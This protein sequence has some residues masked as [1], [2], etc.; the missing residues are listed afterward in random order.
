[1]ERKQIQV[2]RIRNPQTSQTIKQ[3]NIFYYILGTSGKFAAN[4]GAN[5]GNKKKKPKVPIMMGNAM[6][7]PTSN[8]VLPSAE[9]TP[10]P[11]DGFD[12]E[13]LALFW[14]NKLDCDCFSAARFM[15]VELPHSI[16]AVS[17]ATVYV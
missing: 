8:P 6:S 16:S 14:E 15:S 11:P 13:L 17:S 9:L 3:N 5:K 1:M 4:C 7:K 12:D 10:P 2:K